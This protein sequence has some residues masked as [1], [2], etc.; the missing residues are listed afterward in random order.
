MVNTTLPSECANFA[1]PLDY[2]T[3]SNK[4]TIM[5]QIIRIKA[6]VQPAKG[7]IFLALKDQDLMGE[8]LW[9]QKHP[10]CKLTYSFYI[11]FTQGEFEHTIA[12]MWKQATTNA[13]VCYEAHK[14]TQP[15]L[16][17]ASVARDLISVIDA[18]VEDGMLRY[19]GFSYGT[20]LGATV[21]SMFLDRI[22]KLVMDGENPH[23]YYHAAAYVL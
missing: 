2:T 7:T 19:W 18:F 17:T 3:P 6:Q 12:I 4:G 10:R 11:P 20:T 5:L 22:D 8:L 15:G 1:V 23:E 13:E 9:S 14:K 21:A 16:G